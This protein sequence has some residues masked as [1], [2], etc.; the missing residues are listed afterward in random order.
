MEEKQIQT[1]HDFQ[2]ARDNRSRRCFAIG[3]FACVGSRA[4]WQQGLQL[5]KNIEIIYLEV[6]IGRVR[7]C[8]A[9]TRAARV[10]KES[11]CRRVIDDP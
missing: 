5:P 3:C 8:I 9:A 1:G 10:E 6:I 7:V 2:E 11:N 4:R